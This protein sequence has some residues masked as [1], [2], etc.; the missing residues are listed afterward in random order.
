MSHSPPQTAT[1]F[2]HLLCAKI[3]FLRLSLCEIQRSGKSSW[4]NERV[5][6]FVEGLVN[7]RKARHSP[8]FAFPGLIRDPHRGARTAAMNQ[9]FYPMIMDPGSQTGEAN[10]GTA[11]DPE[12]PLRSPQ[13][14]YFP[15]PNDW[16]SSI[17]T[18]WESRNRKQRDIRSRLRRGIDPKE[19]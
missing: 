10:W 4:W 17:S 5:T 2:T 11:N 13:K 8:P 18:M 6:I 3:R 9:P 19:I 15:Q 12:Y 7:R 16:P 1:V 14:R